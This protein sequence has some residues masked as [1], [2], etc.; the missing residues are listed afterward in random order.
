M[1]ASQAFDIF[2]QREIVLKGGADKTRKNYLCGKRSFLYCI[3]DIPVELIS[4]EN[5]AAWQDYMQRNGNQQSSIK[6]RLCELRQLLK[7]LSKFNMSVMNYRQIELPNVKRRTHVVLDYSEIQQ[8]I[9]A[10]ASLRDKAI[11]ACLFATGCRVSELLNLN[12]N[13]IVNGEATVMGK[14]SKQRPVFFDDK[15][16]QYLTQYLQTRKDTLPPLF[17]SGQ[18]RRITVSRVEQIIHVLTAHAGIDKIVTPHVFRHSNITDYIVNGAPMG[19]VQA[20]AGHS[21]I[22]TTLDIYTHVPTQALRDTA[23]NYHATRVIATDLT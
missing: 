22:K 1:L 20:M 3:G 18:Y 6:S 5:V 4:L 12:R 2:I 14:G 16:L 7:F 23:K 19:I 9:D 8:I 11:V 10:A 17:V 21:S 15:S 13:D